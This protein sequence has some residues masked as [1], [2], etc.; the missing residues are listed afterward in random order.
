LD[1]LAFSDLSPA[2]AACI[3]LRIACF[4]LMSYWTFC[5]DPDYDHIMK[6]TAKESL[7]ILQKVS[8][9]AQASVIGPGFLR[10]YVYAKFVSNSDRIHAVEQW[11]G[12]P[13]ELE[14]VCPFLS[15]SDGAKL[16]HL[17]LV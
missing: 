2:R 17:F 4:R 16:E 11:L 7:N 6:Q 8:S 13:P 12:S 3:E 10:N 9:N 14:Y 1:S 15:Y 5:G